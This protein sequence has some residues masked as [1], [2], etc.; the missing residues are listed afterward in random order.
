MLQGNNG[1][2]YKSQQ[3]Q[4]VHLNKETADH[5]IIEKPKTPYTNTFPDPYY[6]GV[7]NPLKKRIIKQIV[8][9]DTRFRD[10]YDTT[11]ATNFH[12]T[13]PFRLT[14]VVLMELASFEYTCSFYAI[15][16]HLGN[17]IV[18]IRKTISGV[19]ESMVIVIPDG[20]YVSGDL[21]VYLNNYT[22]RYVNDQGQSNFQDIFFYLDNI[23]T[24]GS[25]TGS[26]KIVITSYPINATPPFVFPLVPPTL[27]VPSNFIVDWKT[28]D[29]GNHNP[30][31]KMNQT[32]GWLFGYRHGTG[33]Y[34]KSSSYVSEALVDMT[35]TKYMYLVIND[36]N[37]NTNVNFY[38]AFRNSIVNDNTFAKLSI[39]AQSFGLDNQNKLQE[40]YAQPREYFGPVVIQKL[41]IQLLDEYGRVID[42][43]RMDY[44]FSLA[45]HVIYDL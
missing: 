2:F 27:P 20:N 6:Q 35:G 33:I 8:T 7:I 16:A 9:I 14:N 4:Q 36:F 25:N 41:Q 19:E 38:G 11:S 5:D 10:H 12:I 45:F 1:S 26:A 44:S 22:S 29:T 28:D 24:S 37:S 31:K 42:M 3:L 40:I 30:E 34:K 21:M 18:T 13:L 23:T 17:N 15:S 39:N 32:L 43:N